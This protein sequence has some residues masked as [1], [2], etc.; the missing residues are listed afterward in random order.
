[1]G[2]HLLLSKGKNSFGMIQLSYFG[3]SFLATF[4][5]L[6][7]RFLYRKSTI[8]RKTLTFRKP[9]QYQGSFCLVHYFNNIALMR[10]LKIPITA[11]CNVIPALGYENNPFAA[12]SCVEVA[13]VC[14][15]LKASVLFFEASKFLFTL[16][17]SC[18]SFFYSNCRLIGLYFVFFYFCFMLPSIL[19]DFLFG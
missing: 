18:Y 15:F 10:G 11:A 19:L 5:I 6:G 14:L 7:F 13:I 8:G 2:K 1:M 9:E 17:F 3:K 4:S 12:C 16:F